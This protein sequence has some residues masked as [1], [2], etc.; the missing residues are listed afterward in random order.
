M[1]NSRAGKYFYCGAYYLHILLMELASCKFSGPCNFGFVAR[2]LGIL[3][4]PA[5]YVFFHGATAHR[6]QGLLIIEA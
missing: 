5:L 1:H 3:C 6:G 2:F 4:T